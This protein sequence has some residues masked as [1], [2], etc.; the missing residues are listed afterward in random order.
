MGE[1]V[2]SLT[3]TCGEQAWLFDCRYTERD[4]CIKIQINLLIFLKYHLI[5][6]LLIVFVNNKLCIKRY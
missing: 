3:Y 1:N 2:A 6:K 4:F 5:F